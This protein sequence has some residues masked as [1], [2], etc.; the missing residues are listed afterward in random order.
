MMTRLDSASLKP[1]GFFEDSSTFL[2]TILLLCNSVGL[3]LRTRLC[4]TLVFAKFPTD[5]LIVH[6]LWMRML[7][8]CRTNLSPFLNSCG[9][10]ALAIS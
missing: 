2:H 8:Q 7:P 1:C 3:A 9:F 4:E 5:C 6:A 10:P